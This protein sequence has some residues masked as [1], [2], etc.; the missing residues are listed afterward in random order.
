[1]ADIT[2]E[3]RRLFDKLRA[4]V[5][6]VC[7]RVHEEEMGTLTQESPLT[8]T[9]AAAIRNELS[10]H[11]LV[12]GRLSIEV[13]ARNVPDRG[14]RS[15]ESIN[16]ADLYLSLVRRDKAISKGILLQ[17]KWEGELYRRNRRLRNQS[18]RMRTR[19][20]DGSFILVFG[21]R[22]ILAVPAER[23]TW[24]RVPS[25]FLDDGVSVGTLIAEGL[26]CN[27]GDRGI[28][29]DLNLP[30]AKAID[31][32]LRD[33]SGADQPMLEFQVERSAISRMRL[34]DG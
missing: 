29:R 10:H 30:P 11:G 25:D 6:Q 20:K 28:G 19:S 18:L 12:V 21:A 23:A 15:M 34:Q 31:K 17:S 3:E 33:I 14:P 27:I 8:A 26:K 13:M 5:D 1:M 9:I 16:G 22:S 24:P 7:A 2:D 32:V 4:I